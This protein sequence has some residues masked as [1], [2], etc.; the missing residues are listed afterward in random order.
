MPPV[1]KSS[2]I[3]LN[4]SMLQFSA[5]IKKFDQHAEK[6]GWT[7]I[8]VPTQLAQ[9]LVPANKRSFRIKGFLDEYKFEQTALVPFGGGDFILP[10]NAAM[11]KATG[12]SKGASITIKMEVDQAEIKP[13]ADL[14][15]CLKDEPKALENFN[16]LPP[17]HKKYYSKWIESAKTEP[18]KARRIAATI[19]VLETG[20]SLGDAMRLVGANKKELLKP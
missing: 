2:W 11:R 12:K 9:Q 1:R 5:I 7:Y 20:Q 4:L 10:I 17:S 19:T 15:E 14:V 13:S 16:K 8:I 18:T 3:V 6:T